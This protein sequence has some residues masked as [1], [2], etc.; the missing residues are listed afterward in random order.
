MNHLPS[1]TAPENCWCELKTYS[2][3]LA[4][5]LFIFALEVGGAVASGSLALWGDAGHVVTDVGAIAISIGISYVV[6]AGGH[7]KLY[8]IGGWIL[9]TLLIIVAVWI[10]K[11]AIDRLRGL[12]HYHVHGVPMLATAVM[13]GLLNRV[14]HKK[15]DQLDANHPMHRALTLHVRS[16]WIQSVGVVGGGVIIAVAEWFNTNLSIIDPVGSLAIALWIVWQTHLLVNK[17][18]GD[19]DDHDHGHAHH[20]H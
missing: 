20:H 16:D 9:I 15:L 1:C 2:G 18:N 19:G 3:V 11:E 17:M 8:R 4:L 14:Q 13:G 12:E 5:G 10:T 6:R 7:E